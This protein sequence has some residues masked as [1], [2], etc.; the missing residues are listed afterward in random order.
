MALNLLLSCRG[1]ENICS[2][3]K[4]HGTLHNYYKQDTKVLLPLLLYSYVSRGDQSTAL[5]S[6]FLSEWLPL[7]QMS[8]GVFNPEKERHCNHV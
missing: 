5:L 4:S 6:D 1:Q 3:S 7:S 2:L 8:Y